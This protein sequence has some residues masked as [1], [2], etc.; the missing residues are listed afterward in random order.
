MIM[1]RISIF[2]CVVACLTG[3]VYLIG[4]DHIDSPTIAETGTD[5]TDYYAFESP[6]NDDNMVF[7][8]NVKGLLTPTETETA[9]FD[10]DVMLEVNIDNSSS[11]D[12]IEDLV[13]Q[14]VFEDGK[15]KV[16]GPAAPVEKGVNSTLINS[17]TPVEA[18]ITSYGDTPVI[19]SAN[20]TKVFAG[21]RDD[22]F[23]FDLAA[24]QAIIGGTATEFEDPGT[25]TFA[26][27]NVLSV[28]V[29]VPKSSLGTGS[30]NTWVTANR[31][32]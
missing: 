14:A 13:I 4:A 2:L 8:I 9:S 25:D 26:G 11:K 24:Y 31:K 22:P 18:M 29:E 32:M 1:K 15:V 23:F 16:Y 27:T 12:A 20:G 17:A 7:V 6:E 28:V 5:I 19:G 30:V 3:T 21:P 10:E